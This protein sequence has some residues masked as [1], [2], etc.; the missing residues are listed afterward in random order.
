MLVGHVRLLNHLEK[1][2]VQDHLKLAPLMGTVQENVKP[3]VLIQDSCFGVRVTQDFVQIAS[4]QLLSVV[5]LLEEEDNKMVGRG[6][7]QDLA[8]AHF[9]LAEQ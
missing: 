9:L 7:V 5:T 4:L 6:E 8:L 1:N 3:C 2:S